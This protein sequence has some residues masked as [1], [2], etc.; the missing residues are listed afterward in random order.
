M[1]FSG[2]QMQSQMQGPDS[3]D[4]SRHTSRFSDRSFAM[5]VPL[6][7]TFAMEDTMFEQHFSCIPDYGELWKTLRNKLH[8]D[9]TSA[10]LT[11]KIYM[12]DILLTNRNTVEMLGEAINSCSHA[13]MASIILTVVK[14]ADFESVNKRTIFLRDSQ[15]GSYRWV[16]PHVLYLLVLLLLTFALNLR[17]KDQE[18]R[19][20]HDYA[21]IEALTTTLQTAKQQQAD[22]IRECNTRVSNLTEMLEGDL[23]PGQSATLDGHWRHELAQRRATIRD[24][25]KTLSEARAEHAKQV[26]VYNAKVGNLTRVLGGKDGRI[27]ELLAETQEQKRTIESDAATLDKLAGDL[28]AAKEQ[29]TRA[30]AEKTAKINELTS[31]LSHNRTPL[32]TNKLSKCITKI[33]NV[34]TWLC[35][36]ECN[37]MHL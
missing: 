26:G 19:I 4:F 18:G 32:H 7:I 33:N 34:T 36:A 16:C 6:H 5:A 24:L 15:K 20:K 37:C 10:V 22:T 1:A 27:H 31:M 13:S 35:S 11:F 2:I 12:D 17:M 25:T 30:M 28:T 9:D 23:K 14:N 29:H 21:T 3:V 8:L